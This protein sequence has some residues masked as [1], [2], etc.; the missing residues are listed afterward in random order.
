[1]TATSTQKTSKRNWFTREKVYGILFLG[2]GLFIAFVFAGGT[3]SGLMTTFGLTPPRSDSLSVP[4]LVFPSQAS[5]YV[6][7]IICIFFGGWQLAR[8]F[9][10]VNIGLTVVA[11]VFVVAF[12]AWAAR[13]GSLNV[14]SLMANALLR[15]TPIALAGLSGVLCERAAV[16]NIAIEGMMLGSAFSSTVAASVAGNVWEWSR[17]FTLAFGLA[18]GLLTGALLGFLLAVLAVRYK[19]DQIVAGTAINIFSTGITSFMVSRILVEFQNLNQTPIFQKFPLP[20]LS[21]IPILGTVFFNQNLLFYLMFVVIAVIH[22]MLFYTRWGLRT[23]AVGEHPKAADTLGVRVYFNRYVNT[24]LGGMVA[25]LG[26]SFL[27]L[28]S[29]GR[30]DEVMTAGKGFIG[31]AAMIFGKWMPIG[32]FGA[33][34]IFGFADSLQTKLAILNVPIPSQFL[35]MAPYLITIVVLAGVIGEATPPAADGQPY[36]KE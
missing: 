18:M 27:I 34:S 22:I 36:V 12:L 6:F 31:L 13:G 15:A 11:L 16:I 21:K 10:K 17:G 19:V 29:V 24:T 1:M 7:S 26:G 25:G 32:T 2:V 35:L 9:K 5:L 14:T 3:E 33:A 20:G 4:D 23:R 8:G 30:F 28:G